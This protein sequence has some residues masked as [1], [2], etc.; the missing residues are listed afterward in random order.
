[1]LIESGLLTERK[2]AELRRHFPVQTSTGDGFLSILVTRQLLTPWQSKKIRNGKHRGFFLGPYQLKSHLARGGMSTLYVARHSE[3]GEACALKVLPPSKVGSSSHLPRFLR[4]A[5]LASK[6][7]HPNIMKVHEVLSC[8]DHVHTIHFMAM[9]LLDGRDLFNEV[10]QKGPL[11]VRDAV[12]IIRQSAVGL[13]AAH[14][15]GLVHRDV[16]PGNIFL[17]TDGTVKIVDLGLAAIL[18][19]QAESLTRHHDEKV[20]GTA[21]YL[22][23][24][25]AIDSHRVDSRADIYALACAFY[26]ALTGRPP[27]TEGSLAQRILAHQTKDPA[28]IRD[29]RTD[30]PKPIR[31]I[32]KQMFVKRRSKR[33]Q[34]CQ[35]VA[36]RLQ[37]WLDKTQDEDQSEQSVQLVSDS[38]STT[39][40]RKLRRIRKRSSQAETPTDSIRAADTTTE[41]F[42][43]A[44]AN[45]ANDADSALPDPDDLQ[46]FFEDLASRSGFNSSL[47]PNVDR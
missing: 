8:S 30:V 6:L 4:E 1:M 18:E 35:E 43:Q 19:G 16:K 22:A 47:P 40:Q 44:S 10:F 24:E 5:D 2:V 29:F 13:Q 28:D 36:D 39:R 34:T 11:P 26:Y 46:A 21:D 27:F 42:P 20:L 23:P 3:T 7:D 33:I 41:S 25:Q 31:R 14:D 9:E 37:A 17:T 38:P 45:P 32:L 15:Y 12:E